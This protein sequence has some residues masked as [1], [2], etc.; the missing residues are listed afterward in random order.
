MRKKKLVYNTLSALTYEIIALICGLIL[1]RAILSHFGSDVNGLVC[2]VTQFLLLISLLDM[3]V[4][5][6]VQSALYKP[7]AEHNDVE[8]SKVLT[9]AQHFFSKIGL[10]FLIYVTVLIIA[11]PIAINNF[12]FV[13]TASLIGA[14][15]IN[16][17]SQY[18]FGVVNRLLLQASQRSYIVSILK[19]ITCILNTIS[20][21]LLIK[22]DMSIQI[23]K[24]NTS[25]IYL[26]QPIGMAIYVKKHYSVN[27]HTEYESEPIKQKW[28]GFSQHLA[29]VVMGNTDTIVLT[30]F[31]SLRNVSIYNVYYMVLNNVKVL[32]TSVIGGFESL[33]GELLARK[34]Y[35]R[36]DELF[37][38]YE[39]CMHILITFVYCC[40]AVLILPF[41][42]VYTNGVN[43]ANYIVPLFAY[44]I[45]YANMCHCYRMPYNTVIKAAGH[46]KET[47]SSAWIEISLNITIS[48]VSVIKYGL[49]GVAV[50][51]MIAMLYR[52]TYFAWYL[53]KNI[54]NRKMS[55]YMK[56][57]A[58]NAFCVIG[59]IV[60]GACVPN[61]IESYTTWFFLAI[62]I[63]IIIGAMVLI[64][65]GVFF[66]DELQ[67]FVFLIRRKEA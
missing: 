52:T 43:D 50:G 14:V 27:K 17:F 33:I 11:Y 64:F 18:Y 24:L 10:I 37:S 61:N 41:V 31:S 4:G 9:S 56:H 63:A 53:S 13:Y 2:S 46:Y 57:M 8:A 26:L 44:I 35:E 51:T 30:I 15:A 25:L 39:T 5:S 12:G 34:E 19:I 66:R 20:C 36:V 3:G 62:R 32:I 29:S 58:I 7:L 6:V 47:Q 45:S 21:I 1:P 23:V 67:K 59:S 28:N 16:S 22:M 49:I 42:S 54:L 48:V 65:N 38:A 40:T 55:I 60:L